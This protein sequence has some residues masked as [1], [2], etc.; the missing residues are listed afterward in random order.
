M[1]PIFTWLN[2]LAMFWFVCL[3]ATHLYKNVLANVVVVDG[4]EKLMQQK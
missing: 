3:F 1:S 4:W 2:V